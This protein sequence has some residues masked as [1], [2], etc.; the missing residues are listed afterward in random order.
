MHSTSRIHLLLIV[1][2]TLKDIILSLTS[3]GQLLAAFS[4]RNS[5]VSSEQSSSQRHVLILENYVVFLLLKAAQARQW[6]ESDSD[7]R[8]KQSWA[9]PWPVPRSTTLPNTQAYCAWTPEH[10][11][12][13]TQPI[14][15]T[16]QV[17]TGSKE[18]CASSLL[19]I[20]HTYLHIN[21][22][23]K[24]NEHSTIWQEHHTVTYIFYTLW[25]LP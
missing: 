3:V 6:D 5:M 4:E 19:S 22:V 21:D 17:N 18:L 11:L 7:Y 23:R 14:P 16:V 8:L 1:R 20:V 25:S 12:L 9:K 24:L 10:I 15:P 13:Y 2:V